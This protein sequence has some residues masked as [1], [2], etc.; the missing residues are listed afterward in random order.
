MSIINAPQEE[1]KQT[2]LERVSNL[3][4]TKIDIV[5]EINWLKQENKKLRVKRKKGETETN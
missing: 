1:A 5:A 4:A 3:K 2:H